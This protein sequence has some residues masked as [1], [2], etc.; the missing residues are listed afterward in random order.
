[1]GVHLTPGLG[2]GGIV[3]PWLT[4]TVVPPPVKMPVNGAC[5]PGFRGVGFFATVLTSFRR[6][7]ITL[8][9]TGTRL[10][11]ETGCPTA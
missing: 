1:L 6:L 8:A 2:V 11:R 9:P 4:T 3:S 10:L 7:E 5:C